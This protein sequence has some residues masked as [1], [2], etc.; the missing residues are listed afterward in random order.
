MQFTVLINQSRSLE[1]NLNAQ[2]AFL[3]AYLFGCPAWAETCNVDGDLYFRISKKKV[4]EDLPLLT[5]KPNTIHKIMKSLEVSGLILMAVFDNE[6]HI[7]ITEKGTYWNRAEGVEK[8]PTLGNISTQGVEKNPEGGGKK[9]TAGVEK[10]PTNQS[11]SNKI[12]KSNNYNKKNKQETAEL[13]YSVWPE[14]PEQQ[15]FDDWLKMRKEKNAPISQ[16]VLNAFGKEFY[17]AKTFGYSVTD[18][19]TIA[20]TSGK[21]WT[22]FKFE[23][24]QNAKAGELY[25]SNRHT[26]RQAIETASD[27]TSW[28]APVFDGSHGSY[29]CE[30]SVQAAEVDIPRVVSGNTHRISHG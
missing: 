9:S 20:L 16:T 8:N 17:K 23:W 28:A 15:V 21:G 11:I 22:G 24:V 18:C 5:D 27:D 2:Q 19:L 26:A 7:S 30:R 3:F 12:I 25:G 1:W 10:N 14:L 4:C 13:D 29:V 6:T